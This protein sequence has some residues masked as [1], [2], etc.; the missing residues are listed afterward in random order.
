MN[1][2]L[3]T[4][5][6]AGNVYN[7]A[8]R[9][10]EYQQYSMNQPYPASSQ[11]GGQVQT[12]MQDTASQNNVWAQNSYNNGMYN[13]N[14]MNNNYG[15]RYSSQKVTLNS[16]QPEDI[17][18]IDGIVEFSHITRFYE[19]EEL[20]DYNRRSNSRYPQTKPFISITISDPKVSALC[21]TPLTAEYID[22]VSY[23][24]KTSGKKMMNLKTLSANNYN[25]RRFPRL[26][27]NLADYDQGMANLADL[28]MKEGHEPAKGSRVTVILKVYGSNGNNSG[29]IQEVILHDN[30]PRFYS[31]A[32]TSRTESQLEALGITRSANPYT[33]EPT[34]VQ[35][36]ETMEEDFHH[37][38]YSS[39]NQTNTQMPNNGYRNGYQNQQQYGQQSQQTGYGQNQM[40]QPMPNNSGYS[41]GYQNQNNQQ[42][43]PDYTNYQQ[44]NQGGYGSNQS[45]PYNPNNDPNRRY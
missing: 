37:A 10:A 13:K 8:A 40:S 12:M 27:V 21:R 26:S 39:Q 5:E 9:L 7:P 42:Y 20:D 44:G 15:G 11:F 45:G 4:P 35:A 16:F 36:P 3:N 23:I 28:E 1:N 34:F 2:N 18:L 6:N 32:N 43:Q 33:Q 29:S 22:S 41:N 24:S 38:G 14:Y 19:G 25:R 30:P 17:L 31:R